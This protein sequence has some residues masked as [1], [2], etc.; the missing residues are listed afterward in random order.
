M[1][2]KMGLYYSGG[3]DWSFKQTAISDAYTFL[4][5][6][7]QE[8]EYVVYATN[9]VRE[10]IDCYR[11]S[12]LWNDIR[13]P[14]NSNLIEL[15]S[16]YYNA[17]PEGVINDRWNQTAYPENP[18]TRALI[19]TIAWFR[20][21]YSSEDYN[22]PPIHC[23]YITPEYRV[24]ERISPRKWEACRGLGTSFGYNINET[25]NNLLTTEE[26]IHTFVDIV[27]KNGNLLIN[28][29]PMA[30]GKIPEAQ[31]RRLEGLGTWLAVNGEAIYDT[32]PWIIAEGKTACGAR[33]RYTQKEDALYAIVLG[34]IRNSE[35]TIERL[36]CSPGASISLLDSK[37]LLTW[38]QDGEH[39]TLLLPKT[40]PNSP[41]RA[42]KMIPRPNR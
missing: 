4:T 19:N 38:R 30:D 5:N 9:Q 39:V 28:V 37:E 3:L 12:V 20:A 14:K 32:R 17:V 34:P 23:D 7:P 24:L 15:F 8:K 10:L 21:K 41:A 11:P 25:D 40:L 22:P 16:Y 2:L 6:T 31:Q 1:G 27:S 33:V 18:I 29:G 36:R 35:I 42:F 13:W 26:L